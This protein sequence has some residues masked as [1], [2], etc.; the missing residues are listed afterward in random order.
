MKYYPLDEKS[1]RE[2]H[3]M[4][5]MFGF[6]SDEP[7]YRE[8]VDEAYA[9][10]AEAADRDPSCE[11]KAYELADRYSKKMADWYNKG[12]R[13]DSMCPSILVS[14]GANFPVRKKERQNQA[15]DNHCRELEKLEGL[16]GR[17]R[18]MGTT[19]EVIKSG[20]GDAI[21]KLSAKVEALTKK[22]EDM[23][24]ANAQ[25]RKDGKT[26]PF[27]PF[28]LSNN[29]QNIRA[30]KRR[31][32]S[33]KAAKEQ[34][35][36]RQHIELMGESAEVVENAELMRLQLLFGGK[37]SEQIRTQLKKHGFRWSPKNGA[38]QR[39]LTDNARYA[40]KTLLELS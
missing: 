16:K 13:I 22:Q 10:A 26:A 34:G 6:R 37:P 18:R 23:K 21:E 15:R 33:L 20:A 30:T 29:N 3:A 5:S 4:N 11:V 31:I 8:C 38:W 36:E 17:I 1:A 7:E 35:T 24:A 40:L 14:G 2:A 28:K 9:L 25:A 19:S 12:Y 27:P 39:Q 32:E